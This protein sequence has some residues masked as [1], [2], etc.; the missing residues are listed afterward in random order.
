RSLSLG[1]AI[2]ALPIGS[3]WAHPFD[4]TEAD[5][6]ALLAATPVALRGRVIDEHGLSIVGAQLRLIG[7]GDSIGNDGE[8]GMSCEGGGFELTGLARR[9]VLLEV[10]SAGHYTEILPIELQVGLDVDEVELGD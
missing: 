2:L 6:Q 1:L 10:S 9:N 5:H 7:W 4:D 3:A 8:A